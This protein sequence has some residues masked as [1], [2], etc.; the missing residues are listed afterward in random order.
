MKKHELNKLYSHEEG[1]YEHIKLDHYLWN[2][3]FTIFSLMKK[4]PKDLI[5]VDKNILKNYKKGIYSAWIPYNKCCK[6]NENKG[7]YG[8]NQN[9]DSNDEE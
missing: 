6:K 1:F 4:N 3:I 2:Y 9:E 7:I 5:S 8:E